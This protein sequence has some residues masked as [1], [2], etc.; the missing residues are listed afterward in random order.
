[1]RDPG[2]LCNPNGADPGMSSQAM[3]TPAR[4]DLQRVFGNDVKWFAV[5][6]GGNGSFQF[7]L[8]RD[9]LGLLSRGK[10]EEL[11]RVPAEKIPAGRALR[12]RFLDRADS[13]DKPKVGRSQ[14]ALIFFPAKMQ[15]AEFP[16]RDFDV[17]FTNN[18]ERQIEIE[19]G[20]RAAIIPLDAEAQIA[21]QDCDWWVERFGVSALD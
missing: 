13:A 3:T 6:A 9:R 1:W 14:Q 16:R 17:A 15:G 20:D 18:L 10:V 2:V 11:D 4:H 7:L 19:S 5:A 21:G 8:F 12:N